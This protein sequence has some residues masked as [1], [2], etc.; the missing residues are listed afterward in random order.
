MPAET[1]PIGQCQTCGYESEDHFDSAMITKSG[2][3]IYRRGVAIVHRCGHVCE[4]RWLAE[5][6]ESEAHRQ[7]EMVEQFRARLDGLTSGKE[8]TSEP[9][10]DYPP[11]VRET[12]TRWVM[13]E[14][15]PEGWEWKHNFFNEADQTMYA[16]WASPSGATSPRPFTKITEERWISPWRQ[17]DPLDGDP[18]GC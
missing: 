10:T 7:A 15:G 6:W 8:D 16:V 13:L 5:H 2:E 4:Y 12:Q 1:L 17:I 9:E 11:V 3:R 18:H 14:D